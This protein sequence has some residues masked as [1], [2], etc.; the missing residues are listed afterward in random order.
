[1]YEWYVYYITGIL[2]EVF[3]EPARVEIRRYLHN[4]QNEDG[5][6]GLHIEGNS[7]MFGSSLKYE[8]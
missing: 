7:T 2:D 1:M 4:H 3:P 8:T 6:W 5:G